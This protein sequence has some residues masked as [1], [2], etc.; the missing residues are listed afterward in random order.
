MSFC[1]SWFARLF[2]DEFFLE[3]V[4]NHKSNVIRKPGLHAQKI[5]EGTSEIV[6]LFGISQQCA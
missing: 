4:K 3:Y 1:L 5:V 2:S 6:P